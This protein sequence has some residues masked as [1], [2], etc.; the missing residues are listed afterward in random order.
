[1]AIQ[2]GVSII[3]G[4]KPI[5]PIVNIPDDAIRFKIRLRN[6]RPAM[7]FVKFSDR[8]E[9]WVI[10]PEGPLLGCEEWKLGFVQKV[11]YAR[12]MVNIAA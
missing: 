3:W 1:V 4:V 9:Q 7:A 5:K 10:V 8:V 12:E 11:N 6:D 2:K